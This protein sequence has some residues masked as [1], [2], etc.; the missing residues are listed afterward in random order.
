M[1]MEMLNT[2]KIVLAWE[3]VEQ[4]IA[5]THIAEKLQVNRDA[6]KPCIHSIERVGLV[7]L[8]DA[9]TNAKRVHVQKDKLMP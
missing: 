1:L 9:Y 7:A 8:L 4:G 2:T 3:L 5:R 6:V